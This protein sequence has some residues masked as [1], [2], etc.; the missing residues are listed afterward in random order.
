[1]DELTHTTR[2]EYI[3]EK[4]AVAPFEGIKQQKDMWGGLNMSNTDY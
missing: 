3:G 1:M 4:L 2:N